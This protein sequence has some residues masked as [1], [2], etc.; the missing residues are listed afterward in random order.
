[1]SE[2]SIDQT[3]HSPPSQTHKVWV[4]VIVDAE[5]DV[6]AETVG[7]LGPIA[8]AVQT[9]MATLA[10]GATVTDLTGMCPHCGT[11]VKLEQT[12]TAYHDWP[13]FTRQVCP[14]SRQ[15]ARCAESDARPLWN[16]KPNPHLRG[17]TP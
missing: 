8:E 11:I 5:G 2:L 7:K 3:W 16:G 12:L 6:P 15:N 9:Y 4:R 13:L 10:E 1:M 17:E 14:G